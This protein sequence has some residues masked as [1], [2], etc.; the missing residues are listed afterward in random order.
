VASNRRTKLAGVS[1]N[2]P[3]FTL[4]PGAVQDVAVTLASVP[5]AGALYGAVEVIGLPTNAATRKGVVLGYRLL[6]TVRIV[7]AQ[8]KYALTASAPKASQGTAVLPVRNT[9]NTIEPVTGTI[10]VKGASGT[11]NDNLDDVRI[12]PGKQIYVPLG[13]RLAKGSYSMTVTLNQ[14]GRKVLTLKKKFRVK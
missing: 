6:G 1:V 9:G 11:R 8:P 3:S 13:T 7:P 14:H 5:P 4:A 10:R 2:Q 12:L